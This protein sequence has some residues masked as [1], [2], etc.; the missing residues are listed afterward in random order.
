MAP[1]YT[2][3]MPPNLSIR[4]LMDRFSPRGRGKSGYTIPLLGLDNCG[5]TT[6]LH[7][8]K[9]GELAETH[10]CIDLYLE[11]AMV[12]L[13]ASS[14]EPIK[15]PSWDVG[16]CGK[17][18]PRAILSHF[19]QTAGSD[20]L[21]WVVNSTDERLADSVHEL[22]D[23]L[24][25]LSYPDLTASDIPV[26]I[27]ATK[28]DL[29]KATTAREVQNAFAPVVSGSRVFVVGTSLDQ[30]LTEGALADAFRWLLESVENARAGKPPPPSP[31]DGSRSALALEIKLDEWLERAET[32]CSP[33]RLLHQFQTVNMPAWDHYTHIRIIYSILTAFGRHQG[34]DMILQGMEMHAALS[35]KAPLNVTMTYFWIQVVHFAICGMPPA[36]Q[37][38]SDSQSL[39]YL[40][41]MLDSENLFDSESIFSEPG[42][43][44]SLLES[45]KADALNGDEGSAH[46]NNQE[47]SG[48]E[49][50][51]E[52]E[53]KPD[54]AFVRFLL[55]N[56]FVVDKELW[57]EYYSAEVMMSA[58]ARARMVLPDKRRLPNLVGREVILSSLKS[59]M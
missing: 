2:A 12:R 18:I 8:L 21:V 14:E 17:R 23:A 32:E 47:Y 25:L 11:T 41:S 45:E 42:S 29:P 15:M 38:N 4:R 51:G 49:G 46:E 1:F 10:P 31:T 40:E 33:V 3:M 27:L 26:L 43:D 59:S 37:L 20:A 13:Q 28:Q 53:E 36:P 52:S 55:L 16:G 44:W 48:E 30:S 34:R 7:R 58:K 9:I 39:S 54:A 56:P 35:E 19:A 6:L 50:D 5:K 24:D 57:T 22:R